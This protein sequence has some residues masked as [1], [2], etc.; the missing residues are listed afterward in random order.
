M[1]VM[2]VFP[3]GHLAWNYAPLTIRLQ[4][5]LCNLWNL[6]VSLA[7]IFC[8]R[9]FFKSLADLTSARK[10]VLVAGDLSSSNWVILH[11]SGL[12]LGGSPGAEPHSAE[13]TLSSQETSTKILKTNDAT[14]N[15]QPTQSSTPAHRLINPS[16]YCHIPLPPLYEFVC[17]QHECS[18]LRRSRNRSSVSGST[19][20]DVWLR[21]WMGVG[22]VP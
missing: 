19:T 17:K 22:R 10:N 9:I 5:Y 20:N 11:D 2:A 21:R 1:V 15:A 12:A 3:V 16:W 14:T 7:L 4:I 6:F 13:I 8:L 18:S